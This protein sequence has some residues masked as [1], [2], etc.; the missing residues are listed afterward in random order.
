MIFL[1]GNK[2]WYGRKMSSDKHKQK[3]LEVVRSLQKSMEVR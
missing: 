3:W 1:S 2:G